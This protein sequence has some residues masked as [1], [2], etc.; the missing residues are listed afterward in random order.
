[1][2]EDTSSSPQHHLVVLPARQ[3]YSHS[4]SLGN[5]YARPSLSLSHWQ[6]TCGWL[7]S[8]VR[9]GSSSAWADRRIRYQR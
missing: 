4:A 1:M 5:R 9:A 8:D 3:A 2:L 6:N 7:P